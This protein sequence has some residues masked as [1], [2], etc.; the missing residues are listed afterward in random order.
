MSFED[1]IHSLDRLDE[2]LFPFSFSVHMEVFC[3]CIAIRDGVAS[4]LVDLG[5]EPELHAE[6]DAQELADVN[7]G[8]GDDFVFLSEKAENRIEALV[9]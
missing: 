2:E 6:M 5:D 4:I 3:R 7:I 1:E 8:V 9:A